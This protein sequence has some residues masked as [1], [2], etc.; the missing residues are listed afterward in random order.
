MNPQVAKP[1]GL[2]SLSFP[3]YF[4]YNP[5]M[6]GKMPSAQRLAAGISPRTAM[7]RAPLA[8]GLHSLAPAFAPRG[9]SPANLGGGFR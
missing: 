7:V 9:F 6:A 3:R 1:Q 5:Q 2:G 4:H 8:I